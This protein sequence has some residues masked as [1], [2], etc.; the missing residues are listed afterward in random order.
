MIAAIRSENLKYKRSFAKKLAIFAPL[1]FALYG[2]IMQIYLPEGAKPSWE[3]FVSL[4]F[5]WWPLFFMPLGTA[6]LCA[7]SDNRE[8][9]S[10]GYRNLRVHPV[11][12]HRLWYGKIMVLALYTLL[13]SVAL[14][15]IVLLTGSLTASGAIPYVDIVKAAL[16]IWFVS[17][18]LIPIQLFVAT[19]KGMVTSM[20]LG[21]FGMLA[22]VLMAA[23]TAWYALPWSWALR[24]MCPV[25]GVHPNGVRL[26]AGDPLLDTSVIATGM[27]TS[28]VAFA[29]LSWIT[30]IWFSKREVR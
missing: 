14:I 2:A 11:S 26:T 1:F 28:I 7:L 21:I 29:I 13:S 15:I 6:L 23:Q 30:A 18:S 25:I 10:G 22:G 24:L 27:L 19:W 16:L 5:N 4:V 3:T 9:K 17:L 20:A 12:P 8:R